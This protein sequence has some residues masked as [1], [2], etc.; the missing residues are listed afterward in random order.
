MWGHGCYKIVLSQELTAFQQIPQIVIIYPFVSQQHEILKSLEWTRKYILGDKAEIFTCG[1]ID[2]HRAQL[3]IQVQQASVDT[4][5]AIRY[6]SSVSVYPQIYQVSKLSFSVP[7]C[8]IGSFLLTLE[9]S[10]TLKWA[11]LLSKGDNVHIHSLGV[12]F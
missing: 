12:E 1:F 11:A 4:P 10:K 5:K 8:I 3:A 6:Q 9:F 2:Y 7:V